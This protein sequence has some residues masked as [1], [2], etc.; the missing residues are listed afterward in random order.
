M[1][2]RLVLIIFNE[3]T[4]LFIMNKIRGIPQLNIDILMHA[5]LTQV[6]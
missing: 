6:I 2:V 1:V 4:E 5:Q 3:T